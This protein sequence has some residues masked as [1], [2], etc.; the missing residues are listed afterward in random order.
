MKKQLT[1]AQRAQLYKAEGEGYTAA[2]EAKKVS[3]KA[4]EDKQ[5]AK[6]LKKAKKK[7]A[8]KATT[9]REKLGALGKKI[10]KGTVKGTKKAV[11]GTA[12]VYKKGKDWKIT[13]KRMRAGE[14]SL[15]TIV[16][17]GKKTKTKK[18]PKNALDRM[19]EM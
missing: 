3:S 11:K 6:M 7:G 8:D 5:F 2:V 13:E 19:L 1:E 12:K 15:D 10:V 14:R 16:K 18:K 9:K 4:S 17:T